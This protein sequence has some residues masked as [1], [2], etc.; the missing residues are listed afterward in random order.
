MIINKFAKWMLCAGLA[1]AAGTVEAGSIEFDFKD[2]KKVNNALFLLD[3]PLESI[4]GTATGITGKITFDPAKP[5]STKG[6]I[7]LDAK[8]LHVDNPV[9]REHMLDKG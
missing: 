7:T 2:P 6:K 1:A 5:A 3:A 9:M 4:S 8:T